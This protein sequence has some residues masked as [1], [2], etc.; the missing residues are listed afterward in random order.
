M[1]ILKN[2]RHY[3]SQSRYTS[4][5]FYSF[6]SRPH[7]ATPRYLLFKYNENIPRLGAVSRTRVSCSLQDSRQ[8]LW[9]GLNKDRLDCDDI[10]IYSTQSRH[11]ADNTTFIERYVHV[12]R[13]KSC[14]NATSYTSVCDSVCVPETDFSTLLLDMK[15][16]ALGPGAMGFFA[17]L[18]KLHEL[19]ENN[20]TK[21]IKEI[22]GASAGALLALLY[23]VFKANTKEILKYTISQDLI[24]KTKLNLQSFF[25]NYGFIDTTEI[26]NEISKKIQNKTTISNITFKQLYEFNPIK[27]HIAAYCLQTNETE[28]FSVDTHPD[29]V[30]IDTIMASIAVPF[31]FSS[32]ILNGKTY[33]DGGL[34]ESIPVMPFIAKRGEDIYAINVKSKRNESDEITDIKMYTEKLVQSMLKNRIKYHSI[35]T[36]TINLEDFDIFDFKIKDTKKIE[37]FVKGFLTV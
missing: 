15:Y 37:L 27:L 21:N 34:C 12:R 8:S 35:K 28:Y 29:V 33:V 32:C 31:L 23:I 6:N 19:N 17:I 2:D 1:I 7:F 22:S 20:K 18:G 16:L 11:T 30:V 24:S 14:G 9:T 4:S 3:S 10:A 26:K 36:T 13:N 5:S 25:N